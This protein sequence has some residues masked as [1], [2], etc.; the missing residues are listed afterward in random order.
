MLTKSIQFRKH[1]SKTIEVI[2]AAWSEGQPRKGTETS[3]RNFRNCGLLSSLSTT[4]EWSIRDK[5]D[6]TL[7]SEK[8]FINTPKH[9]LDIYEKVGHLNHLLSNAINN[10]SKNSTTLILGGDHSLGSGS[11]HGN[12][13]KHGEDL[14]VLWIDAH[15]D[16]N[17]PQT[18]STKNY[19]GMPLAHILGFFD[20]LKYTGFEWMTKRLKKENIVL[21]GVRDLDEGEKKTIADHKIKVF[22]TFDIDDCGGIKPA[23]AEAMSYLGLA[24]KKNP[25]HVSF[26]IDSAS[27]TVVSATGTPSRYGL[28]ERELIYIMRKVFDSGCLVN[29]DVAELNLKLAD[30]NDYVQYHGDNDLI[31]TNSLTLYN[32]CEFIHYAFGKKHV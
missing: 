21:F 29:L 1:F 26:D 30:E 3:P 27:S 28:S 17:T 20:D 16:I 9:N 8:T 5:G 4:L 25:L 7:P 12:L 14:K 23:M 15:A 11:I 24:K 32:V 18:S 31:T 19:H 22:S 13:L 6:L 2:G 10:S